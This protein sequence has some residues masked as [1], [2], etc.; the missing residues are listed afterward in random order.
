MK[1]LICLIC[2]LVMLTGCNKTTDAMDVA[3]QFRQEL[4]TAASCSFDA[5]ITADYG[6]TCYT[7]LLNCETGN[8]GTLKFA[9]A[10]PESIRDITG[11]VSDAGGQLT[12]DDAALSFPLLADQQLSPISA[13]W[14]LLKALRGGY[15]SS[16]GTVND[17]V[18]LIV[19]DSFEKDPL[20]IHIWLDA[21]NNP[22]LGEI[23]HDGYR[24]LAVEVENFQFM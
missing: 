12:F 1:Q 5:K 23:Y 4:N 14:I 16:A 21:D 18:R 15:I 3:M 10:A 6:N 20:T 8:S 19:E 11:S 17:Q 24:I 9:V 13:P 22:V 2:I 7:F